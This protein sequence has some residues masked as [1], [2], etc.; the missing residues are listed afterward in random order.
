MVARVKTEY[1]NMPMMIT[2]LREVRS[3]MYP[4]GMPAMAKPRVKIVA[5]NPPIFRL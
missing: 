3:R 2:A 5:S 4:V 1:N